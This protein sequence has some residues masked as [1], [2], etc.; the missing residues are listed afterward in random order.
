LVGEV[1]DYKLEYEKIVFLALLNAG[2][3]KDRTR[4]M[5]GGMFLVLCNRSFYGIFGRIFCL[6]HFFEQPQGKRHNAQGTTYILGYFLY[7]MPYA[8]RPKPQWYSTDYS[9]TQILI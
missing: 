8:F 7:L 3:L 4:R 5:L 6:D 1:H 2:S 9:T